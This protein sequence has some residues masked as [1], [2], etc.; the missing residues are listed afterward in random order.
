MSINFKKLK[1]QIEP[2]AL[3]S[4]STGYIFI[5][6]LRQSILGIDSIALK[7][8]KRYLIKVLKE[9]IKYDPNYREEFTL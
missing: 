5:A 2:F 8:S 9:Y 6:D 1:S 3:K 7:G 4:G